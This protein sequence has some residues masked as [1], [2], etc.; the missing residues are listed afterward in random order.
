MN[1]PYYSG[2]ITNYVCTAAC[3]HCMFGSSPSCPKDFITADESE[4]TAALLRE[5][6]TTSVHIGGGEP[7]MNFTAL[8]TLIESLNR[9]N[10][11]IDYIETN[12]FWAK[13]DSIVKKR[14]NELS[15]RG[16]KSVMISAD[17]FHIEYVPLNRVINLARHLNEEGF[18]YFIWQERFLRR[19]L[20]LE[21]NR[22][23]SRKELERILGKNY[24]ADTAREYGVGMNGRALAIASE[25][26][27]KQPY[28]AFLSSPPCRDIMRPQHCHFDLYGNAVPAGCPG[29]SIDTRD[30]LNG[31]VPEKKYPAAALLKDKGV[32]A[33]YSY[34]KE[35]GFIPDE[36]GY[37][38]KCAFCYALRS[39]LI[40]N[41]PSDDLSPACFYENIDKILD[42]SGKE[43]L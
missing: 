30:Y 9:H 36:G 10:I 7:F 22:T 31:N 28:K 5:A 41:A 4:R 26:Y 32:G 27:E 20:K 16:V 43:S 39:Y 25:I 42:E 23:Y 1:T 2:I 21:H 11:A 37:P 12:A 35:R 8:L 38:T 3:R 40:K 24:V 34:A 13:D 29:L 19:L 18:D 15:K 33:L 14:L 6:G 17:P